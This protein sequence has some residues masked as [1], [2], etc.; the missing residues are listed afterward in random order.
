MLLWLGLAGCAAG[1]ERSTPQAT[2]STPTSSASAAPVVRVAE[3]PRRAA[4]PPRGLV[5]CAWEGHFAIRAGEKLLLGDTG[6]VEARFTGHRVNVH[7]ERID[8]AKGPVATALVRVPSPSAG[9][10]LHAKLRVDAVP[11]RAAR[12][13]RV[14]GDVV[15]IPR[16]TALVLA[17]GEESALGV[18]PRY[19]DFGG[20]TAAAACADAELG[21]PTLVGPGPRRTSPMHVVGK[22]VMLFAGPD[23]PNVL[24]L[25]PRHERPTL[26]VI[27]STGSFRRV[28]YDDGLRIDAWV[29]ASDLAAGEGADCDDCHGGIID[30]DDAC[31]PPKG[32]PDEK[33]GPFHARRKVAVRDRPSP[34]GQ[35]LGWLEEDGEVRIVGR[36]GTYARVE[37]VKNEIAP[38][39]GGFWIDEATLDPRGK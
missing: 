25:E 26:D 7:I 22:K 10:R 33:D 32:C 15:V 34:D 6:D 14:A 31:P 13:I 20:V 18:K 37:A 8:T 35:P 9:L 21:E 39:S 29:R 12:D 2:S 16:G 38:P 23:G 3:A 17:S 19:G 36:K 30:V 28:R 5:T 11:L 1:A 27:E 24:E 4:V